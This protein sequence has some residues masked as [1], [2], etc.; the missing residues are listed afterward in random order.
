MDPALISVLAQAVATLTR[1]LA[2]KEEPS[3]KE[4]EEKVVI[5]KQ[6]FEP[7]TLQLGPDVEAKR[8][9]LLLRTK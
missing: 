7:Q 3:T 1:S 8:I 2:N 4:E 5:A 9:T 6:E